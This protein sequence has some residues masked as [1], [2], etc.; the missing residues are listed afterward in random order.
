[1]WMKLKSFIL[2]AAEVAIPK[3]CHPPSVFGGPLTGE[4]GSAYRRRKRIFRSIRDSTSPFASDIRKE[5]DDRLNAAITHSRRIFEHKIVNDCSNN[6]KRFC[7]FFLP[8]FL[9]CFQTK[10]DFC[11]HF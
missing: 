3:C 5:S 4:V 9:F 2:H 7:F 6:P 11:P 10:S 1:M 8:A